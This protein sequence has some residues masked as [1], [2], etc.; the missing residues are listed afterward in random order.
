[1]KIVDEDADVPLGGDHFEHH[2]D[3]IEEE[4]EENPVV[5]FVNNRTDELE[6]IGKFKKISNWETLGR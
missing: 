6:M 1:M 3:E 4:V 2:K 5:V